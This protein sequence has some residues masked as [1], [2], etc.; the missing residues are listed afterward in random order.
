[1]LV[2]IGVHRSGTSTVARLLECLGAKPSRNLMQGDRNN[3]KGYFEDVDVTMFN[4]HRLLQALGSTWNHTSPL[5]WTRLTDGLRSELM[6]E[7]ASILKRNFKPGN[8]ISVLK[9]PQITDLLPFWLEVL[10]KSGYRFKIVC[11]LRDPLSVARSLRV[12][13]GFT[14]Q[15]G[16][17][18]YAAYW[19]GALRAM[20]GLTPSF[21]SYERML[22]DPRGTLLRLSS[23]TGLPLPEDAEQRLA[24]FSKEFLNPNPGHLVYSSNHGEWGT[25]VFQAAKDIYAALLHA[26]ETGIGMK[27]TLDRLGHWGEWLT[28]DTPLLRE[29]DRLTDLTRFLAV[30]TMRRNRLLKGMGVDPLGDSFVGLEPSIEEALRVV[31]ES[32]LF[33]ADHYLASNADVR[34]TGMD[35]LRHY[36]MHGSEEGR[37]PSLRFNTVSYLI[38]HIERAPSMWNPLLSHIEMLR[39]QAE[40]TGGD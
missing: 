3:P 23:E 30:G 29:Y 14:I 2:V 8:P 38:E 24:A 9:D 26:E 1:M 4:R 36:L 35:P 10:E 32:G 5:D 12:R 18:I 13:D 25:E 7:A 17:M 27:E 28:A 40:P 11:A 21:V 31:A 39:N 37:S 19:M 6:V 22:L 20:Q 15:F 33:D 34:M 16:S